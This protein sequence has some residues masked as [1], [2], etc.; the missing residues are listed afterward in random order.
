MLFLTVSL[1]DL[2]RN[3]NVLAQLNY[4]L[5]RGPMRGCV[6]GAGPA[7]LFTAKYLAEAGVPVAVYERSAETFGHY[8]YAIEPSQ[9]LQSIMQQPGITLNTCADHRAALAAPCDFYVLA[10]GGAQRPLSIPGAEHAVPALAIIEGVLR[11]A[12]LPLRGK[13]CIIGLGNVALDCLW[14]VAGQKP[15]VTVIAS[16]DLAE[17]P[18]SSHVLRRAVGN[19]RWRV[20][21]IDKDSG[22]A[23]DGSTA[24]VWRKRREIIAAA[25][26]T[27]GAPLQFVFNTRVLRIEK[28]NSKLE[29]TYATPDGPTTEVFDTV[30]NSTGFAPNIPVFP[31]AK[32]VYRVGWCTGARGDIGDAMRQAKALVARILG[33][34][35]P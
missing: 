31:S 11:G 35:S 8:R 28:R 7:G 17:V 25:E 6:V 19:G 14:H 27:E 12:P 4:S 2:K 16:R 29:V 13:T 1:N 30:I 24:R 18:I 20:Q 21:P 34:P 9:A 3:R 23:R 32:P 22:G 5:P 26:G 33:K 15:D 10:T